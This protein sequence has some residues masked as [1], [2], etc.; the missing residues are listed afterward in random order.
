MSNRARLA[1][2]LGSVLEIEHKTLLIEGAVRRES[3]CWLAEAPDLGF[4]LR[5]ESA[6][7]YAIA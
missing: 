5:A 3:E 6:C 1:E 2:H 4:V 7:L